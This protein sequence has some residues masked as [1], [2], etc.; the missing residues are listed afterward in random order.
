M[1]RPKLRISPFA[2]LMLFFAL[3]LALGLWLLIA[4]LQPPAITHT[5]PYTV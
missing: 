3:M 2:C 1:P 4:G 5:L